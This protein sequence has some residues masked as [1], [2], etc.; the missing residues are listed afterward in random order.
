MAEE[1]KKDPTPEEAE[2]EFQRTLQTPISR[3]D[4]GKAFADIDVNRMRLLVVRQKWQAQ[5]SQM[6]L[7]LQALDEQ[8][9]AL[10]LERA[11]VFRR[12]LIGQPD[13]DGSDDE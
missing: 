10:D 6:T 8:L 12:T 13:G 2:A 5:M 4:A 3:E 11:V 7:R 1:Q 9:T